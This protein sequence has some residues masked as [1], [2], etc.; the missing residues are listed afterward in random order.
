MELEQVIKLVRAPGSSSWGIKLTPDNSVS[1]VVGE[2][3][4]GAGL[5]VNDKIL[6]I[7]NCSVKR[8]DAAVHRLK[9]LKEQSV[10]QVALH[11]QRLKSL[12]SAAAP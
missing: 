6:A 7:D 5:M 11:I 1:T 2:P 8:Q 12:P 10:F 4:S 3:A 9:Q